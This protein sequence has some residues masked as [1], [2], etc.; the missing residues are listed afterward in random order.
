ME[1]HQETNDS[2]THDVVETETKEELDE[3]VTIDAN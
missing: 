2:T 1:Q 3:V